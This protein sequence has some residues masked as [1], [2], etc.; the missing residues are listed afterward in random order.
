MSVSHFCP[1]LQTRLIGVLYRKFYLYSEPH[2][3]LRLYQ[4]LIRPHLEYACSVWDPNL[5]TL[6]G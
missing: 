2:T 1:Q 3:L 6:K 4:S 5:K